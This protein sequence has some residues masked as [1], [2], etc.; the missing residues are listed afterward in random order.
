[1]HVMTSR[2]MNVKNVNLMRLGT[3][4]CEFVD[5]Q[6]STQALGHASDLLALYLQV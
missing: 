1:M 4:H 2:R 5:F 6:F 3:M